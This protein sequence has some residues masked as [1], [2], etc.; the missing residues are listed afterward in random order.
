M[1]VMRKIL[2]VVAVAIMTAMS[3]QAQDWTE[4]GTK[5]ALN[6]AIA[7]GAQ[8]RLTSDITLPEY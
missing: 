5:E 6:G 4:V 3:A 1:I 7:D 8:I 2:L